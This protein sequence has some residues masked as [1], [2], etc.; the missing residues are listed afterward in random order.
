MKTTHSTILFILNIIFWIAFVGLCIKTG[1]ILITFILSL[2]IPEVSK[3]L[4][5]GLNLS[6]LYSYSKTVYS[7]IAILLIV[8]TA[9]KA[10]IAYLIVSFFKL[11][12]LHK[13]FNPKITHIILKISHSALITGVFAIISKG[14][15]KWVAKKGIEVPLD[16]GG[17]ELLFFAGII[18]L[19]ALVFKK[20]ADLQSENELTV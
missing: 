4:Y 18:Y 20:G 12:K 15:S 5:L 9:L 7:F 13:P 2:Y 19:L 16:W 10:Y 8:L 11:F 3:D 1:A 6:Q 14:Y 17:N